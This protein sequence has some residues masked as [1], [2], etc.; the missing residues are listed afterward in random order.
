MINSKKK[1][2]CVTVE[3]MLGRK[4]VL[5]PSDIALNIGS[6]KTLY[7]PEL[8]VNI[9]KMLEKSPY[10]D[11]ADN[12]NN[13]LLRSTDP[14]NYRRLE[15]LVVELG[16]V[17]ESIK[18]KLFSVLKDEG[19]DE[20]TGIK[21]INN[22]DNTLNHNIETEGNTNSTNSTTDNCD[23]E[24]SSNTTNNTALYNQEILQRAINYIIYHN[25]NDPNTQIPLETIYEIEYNPKSTLYASIDDVFT[26]HQSEHRGVNKVKGN[27]YVVHTNLTIK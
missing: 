19:Y 1:I 15:D 4:K 3:G 23:S 17:R 14:I 24:N 10:R 2:R 27:K 6:R 26:P 13:L 16:K 12:L 18:E 21:I 25:A 22:K 7:T 9:I 5:I 20:K 11:V 8:T